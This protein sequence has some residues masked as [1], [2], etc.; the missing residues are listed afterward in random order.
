M[1]NK[2]VIDFIIEKLTELKIKVD[3]EEREVGKHIFV[4]KKECYTDL[5]NFLKEFLMY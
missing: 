3:F 2:E 4:R 5:I 1:T